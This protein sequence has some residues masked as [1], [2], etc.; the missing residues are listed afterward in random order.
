M[1]EAELPE[2]VQHHDMEGQQ[3]DEEM[4]VRKSSRVRCV[5]WRRFSWHSRVLYVSLLDVL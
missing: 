2:D 1:M 3:E 5:E 4:M